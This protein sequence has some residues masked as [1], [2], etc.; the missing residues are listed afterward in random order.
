MRGRFAR[1]MTRTLI[2]TMLLLG[3]A[4][5]AS[6]HHT[7]CKTVSGYEACG[8]VNVTCGAATAT[9]A[10]TGV[11]TWRLVVTSDFGSGSAQL[12]APAAQLAAQ[13]PCGIPG[14]TTGTLYADNVYV[15]SHTVCFT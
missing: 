9:G 5:L 1:R 13:A 12:R 14:C 7:E 15:T 11:V 10:A 2:A 4:P 6:A 8:S 3:L